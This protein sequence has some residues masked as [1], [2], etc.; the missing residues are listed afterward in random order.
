MNEDFYESVHCEKKLFIEASLRKIRF[1]YQ[2]VF[3]LKWQ[4]NHHAGSVQRGRDGGDG[5]QEEER[6]ARHCEESDG[7]VTEESDG[8]SAFEKEVR[9]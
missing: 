2:G 8:N 9:R 4:L 7:D 3:P 1:S 5:A 6:T